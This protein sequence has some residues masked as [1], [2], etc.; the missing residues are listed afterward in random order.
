MKKTLFLTLFFFSPIGVFAESRVDFAKLNTVIAAILD[1]AIVTEQF[2]DARGKDMLDYASF[3]VAP[4]ETDLDK[5]NFAAEFKIGLNGSLWAPGEKSGLKASLKAVTKMQGADPIMELSA[6]LALETQ[7]VALVRYGS[8]KMLL[9]SDP[10]TDERIHQSGE[11]NE[12]NFMQAACNEFRLFPKVSDFTAFLS[13]LEKIA[14][15][16]DTYLDKR[17]TALANSNETWRLQSLNEEKKYLAAALAGFKAKT[18]TSLTIMTEEKMAVVGGTE[19]TQFIFTLSPGRVSIGLKGTSPEAPRLVEGFK[20]GFEQTA[21]I[22]NRADTD[23]EK[24]E[25]VRNIQSA[26]HDIVQLS[27][28]W[29]V[30]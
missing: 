30:E 1:Q 13:G 21:E 22:L 23:P 16:R 12:E 2:K 7:V 4:S 6:N 8:A 19:V 28:E 29:I 25:I 27:K 5:A 18:P 11:P 9:E 26:L 15:A 3:A 17:L 10:C 14:L 24:L 20:M